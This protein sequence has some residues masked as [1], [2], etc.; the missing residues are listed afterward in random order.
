[1][2]MCI[3]VNLC[4]IFTGEPRHS[5]MTCAQRLANVA[6]DAVFDSESIGTT[7]QKELEEVHRNFLVWLG[8]QKM[9]EDDRRA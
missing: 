9:T 8:R 2:S 1:M 4:I 5:W 3:Y 6:V 7:F